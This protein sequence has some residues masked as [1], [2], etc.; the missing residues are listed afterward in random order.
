MGGSI[1][2]AVN[3]ISDVGTTDD[4]FNEKGEDDGSFG[5]ES[6]GDDE[7]DDENANIIPDAQWPVSIRTTC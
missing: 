7:Q 1:N 5:E 3:G 6:S 4:K 2:V